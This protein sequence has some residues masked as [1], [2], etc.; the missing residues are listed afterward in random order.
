M[1]IANTDFHDRLIRSV[2]KLYKIYQGRAGV[3]KRTTNG[4]RLMGHSLSD[5]WIK[6][7]VHG[8]I[9]D[10]TCL[11]I[12]LVGER[13]GG[14]GVKKIR[15]YHFSVTFELMYRNLLNFSVIFS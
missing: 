15:T 6:I 11:L 9:T 10:P 5:G 4:Q 2:H 12:K 8:G 7:G 1:H 13:R 14:G 3:M